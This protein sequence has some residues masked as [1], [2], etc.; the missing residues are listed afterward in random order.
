MRVK[1]RE[2]GSISAEEDFHKRYFYLFNCKYKQNSI[3]VDTER[4]R[5]LLDSN[6]NW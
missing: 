4:L 2:R 5:C 6:K 1:L 3:L